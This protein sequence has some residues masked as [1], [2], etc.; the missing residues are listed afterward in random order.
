MVRQNLTKEREVA[1][2]KKLL[3]MAAMQFLG[4]LYGRETVNSIGLAEMVQSMG[5]KE[6]ELNKMIETGEMPIGFSNDDLETI[7]EAINR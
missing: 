4:F 7:R 6:K 3:R 5:L 1:T 2:N